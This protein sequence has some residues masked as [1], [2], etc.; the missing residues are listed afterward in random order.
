MGMTVAAPALRHSSADSER[1]KPAASVTPVNSLRLLFAGYL[2]VVALEYG[3]LHSTI[4]FLQ[5]LHLSTL[6]HWGLLGILIFSVKLSESLRTRQM[7]LLLALWFM[8]AFSVLHAEIQTRAFELVR[9]QAESVAF[10]LVTIYVLNERRRIDK[11]AMLFALAAAVMVWR[12]LGAMSSARLGG[13][14]APYFMGDN[15][16]FAWGMLVMLPVIAVLLFGQRGLT[17]R[18]LGLAGLAACVVGVVYSQSRGGALGLAAAMLYGWW[19]VST[20]RVLGMVAAIVVAV[21][22]YGVAPAGYFDRMET[23]ATYEEDNSAQGRLE[24]WTRAVEM[25]LEHPLG[26]GA[27]NFPSAYGRHYLDLNST[28]IGWGAARWIAPHSIYF[29]TLGEYG[30]PGL[31]LLLWLIAACMRENSASARLLQQQADPRVDARWPLLVNMS[32]V[33][34]AVAGTFLGGFDYPHLFLL[35]GL[36]LATRRLAASG[37]AADAAEPVPAVRRHPGR[38]LAP[39][40]TWRKA[41]LRAATG[42]VKPSR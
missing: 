19:F 31:F 21:G 34:F 36:T 23:V 8:T 1:A 27:G 40:M 42:M 41:N 10:A 14:A 32:I 28:R 24:A 29:R 15:N 16:D 9:P 17:I 12:N 4:P 39:A 6:L 26:V 3:G 18:L 33:G 7:V 2:F 35:V 13:L 38:A 20:R 11:L 5:A 30:F 22:V 37:A 25:A